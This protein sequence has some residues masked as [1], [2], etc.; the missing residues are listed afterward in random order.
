MFKEASQ[1]IKE[2]INDRSNITKIIKGIIFSYII[3]IPIFIIF[4]FILTYTDFP[5][6]FI[7]PAVVIVTITSILMA[8]SIASKSL[9][10]RGWLNGGI[11]GLI[12]MLVLYLLSS[13]LFNN[14]SLD[15]QVISMIFIGF[16]S[17]SIGGIIGINAKKS[18]RPRTRSIKK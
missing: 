16:L 2:T 14:F 12:Y 7:T 11:V 5:E 13:I 18:S 6:K 17:G 10:S 4:A 8:G 1:N 15:R 3:T 9:K